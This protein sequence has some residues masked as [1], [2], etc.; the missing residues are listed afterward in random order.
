MQIRRMLVSAFLAL[1]SGASVAAEPA[2]YEALRVAPIAVTPSNIVDA[3]LGLARVGPGDFVIDL[4]SGDGR[5]VI[6]AVDR[7][8]AAG[9]FGVDIS[10]QSVTYA[11]ARA[12]EAGI[13]DRVQF[14]RRDL[15][16]TD[17]RRATVVTLYLFPAA[18]P[19]LRTKLLAELAPGTRVVSHDFPFPDWTPDRVS[20]FA[21]SDKNDSVG[22]GDAV[23]Y[24]Y[25]VP[26]R[27]R[28]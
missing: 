15:Y 1:V 19:R 16:S 17:V 3:M 9:G 12:A 8:G 13:A 18:M 10:E 26:A 28:D 23:L 20:V 6:V 22:R 14:Q 11:N 21:A 24:L 5:L 2:D 7:F 25:T 4:G 27:A